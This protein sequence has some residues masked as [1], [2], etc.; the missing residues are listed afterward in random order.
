MTGHGCGRARR[1]E[2][3]G[4]N[5]VLSNVGGLGGHSLTVN[6]CPGHDSRKSEFVI[7]EVGPP[8]PSW[9][10]PLMTATE[11]RCSADRRLLHDDEAG[12]LE[13]LD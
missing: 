5:V 8:Q 13:V 9:P 1:R 6:E 2:A 7:P 10:S 3:R 11:R 4:S 12:S